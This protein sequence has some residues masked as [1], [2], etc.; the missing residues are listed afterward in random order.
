MISPREWI[1]L[2]SLGESTWCCRQEHQDLFIPSLIALKPTVF[3]AALNESSPWE[4]SKSANYFIRAM[5][6]CHMNTLM[7]SEGMAIWC[8][9]QEY[10]VEIRNDSGRS[11][12]VLPRAYWGILVFLLSWFGASHQHPCQIRHFSMLTAKESL[13]A[14]FVTPI[15]YSKSVMLFMSHLLTLGTALLYSPTRQRVTTE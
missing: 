9:K 10:M 8:W 6:D 14:R 3:L 13:D 2:D 7:Q 15:L 11:I 12:Q 5:I 1:A 4:S